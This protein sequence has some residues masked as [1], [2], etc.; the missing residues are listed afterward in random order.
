MEVTDILDR[1]IPPSQRRRVAREWLRA[2]QRQMLPSMR[3][4][5]L[6]P[7]RFADDVTLVAYTFPQEEEDFD[8]IEFAIRQSWHCL[9]KLR[10]VVVADRMTDLV[11][12]FADD[13]SD[14]VEVQIEPSI[15]PGSIDT[16]SRDCIE[17]LWT[18]F[19]TPYC[20]I[21][22]DD[23]FPLRDNL[24]E[25]L[26][27]YDYIGAPLVRDV[28]AQYL[29]DWLRLESLNGGLSLRSRK[30]CRD[31]AMQWKFW[32]HIIKPGSRSYVEDVFYGKTACLNP[33]YRLR[34]RFAP[35]KI[36]RRFSLP[37]FDGVLDIRNH[38]P[39]PFGVHGPT[40]AW[41]LME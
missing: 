30:I 18:R 4:E 8:F 33:L 24:D 10:A 1:A 13:C 40:A 35:C 23:G 41:Q 2:R 38:E 21:V 17:R 3:S 27:K 32:R 6:S 16:M 14:W 25:F 20:L 9:G 39:K 5:V 31:A 29:V 11:K 22:Q 15:V 12:R 7:S 37:D 34:N 36:A 19:S 26:G 28:T